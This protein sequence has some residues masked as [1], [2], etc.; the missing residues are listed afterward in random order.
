MFISYSEIPE[1]TKLFLDYINNF[2]KVQKFYKYNF[3]DKESF[4][5]KFQ[6]LKEYPREFRAELST[7]IN[8]Q[9]KDLAPSSKT[10][11]NISLLK[12]KETLAIVTGQQLGVLGGPMYTF[13]KIITAIKLASHLSERF[14]SYHFVPVFWLEG[15]DHDFD[16]VRMI[17]IL[18]DN[19]EIIKI[20]Y[21]D[22][23]LE[24]ELNR[25]SIGHLKFTDSISKFLNE[26]EAQ[27]RDT[28]FKTQLMENLRNLYKEEKTF[29][30]S[31]KELLFWLFDQYG[32]IIFDPQDARVKELLKPIF[33]K[34]VSNFRSHTENL[35]NTSAKLEEL[36]HA[37]VKIRPINLFYNYDEGRYIIEPF[38][39][40]FRLKGK[41]KKFLIDELVAL[42]DAEP[43]KFS[44]NVLLRPVCQDYLLPTAFYIG[45]PSEIAYFAQILPL[46]EFYNVDPAIIYPRSSA[47]IVEKSVKTILDKFEL[48]L[49]DLFTD[50]NK[51]KNQIISTVSENN[52]ENLFK[53]S[54]NKIDLVFDELKE[55][56]FEIDKTL[57][58]VNSK[59][60]IKVLTYFDELN[61]KASEAQRKRYEI[62]LRQIDKASLILYPNQILQERELN[63]FQF[64]NKYSTEFLKKIFD[65]LAINK[66]EHQIIELE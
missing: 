38:E 43:D 35:V 44:P 8:S 19:N 23:T 10:L 48:E 65:D 41:R 58:E 3:R 63:F 59:Y 56:L 11:K 14:D 32:L 45:G 4:I 52:L 24:E 26:F 61:A 60:R 62:T 30:D 15:D 28:E 55:K 22:D 64:A 50:P 25:G 5:S 16:E 53:N 29:K 66:F 33:K 54:K 31:F 39:N 1:N 2:D 40:E 6:Q 7:I 27:L 49:N 42:I 46:Y 37:Q 17:N 34:E 18:N 20:S 51:L 9:Y 57:L 47:T 12:N 36:Y 13:Y 21:S